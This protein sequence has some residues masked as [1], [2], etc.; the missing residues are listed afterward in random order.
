MW[1]LPVVALLIF[2]LVFLAMGPGKIF[3]GL[4]SVQFFAKGSDS[5]FSPREISLLWKAAR[6]ARLEKP[7]ALFVSVDQ[8]DLTIK[9]LKNE[10]DFAE[11][12]RNSEKIELLKKLFDYRKK[13]EFD[14]PRYKMGLKSTH[15]IPLNQVLKLRVPGYQIFKCM[16]VENNQDYM[17][18][19]YPA[20]PPVG[21]DFSWRNITLN[22]Y[23]WKENDA[24]YFF[25]TSFVEGYRHNKGE[26]MR[27]RHTNSVLRSQKRKSI[28]AVSDFS[29]QIHMI[30]SIKTASDQPEY[31]PG[32]Q[33]RILD[34]SEDGAAVRARGKGKKGLP[35]K[36][37]FS[38]NETIIAALGVV[39][40]LE[41]DQENDRSLL[42]LEFVPLKDEAKM[43]ILSYVYDVDRSR[44]AWLQ[45]KSGSS[46][47]KHRNVISEILSDEASSSAGPEKES[48]APVQ[49]SAQVQSPVEGID[50]QDLL[51]DLPDPDASPLN[52]NIVMDDH[53]SKIN[54]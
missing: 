14:K 27:M 13:I 38:L 19:T 41:Y 26:L 33:C 43:A 46:L 47:N 17:T 10:T 22:V 42:H 32:L 28:R 35:L 30:K 37:Q 21:F 39:K 11:K 31:K 54:P 51:G 6:A 3:G 5:G 20:G 50:I 25:Q 8:L 40:S 7:E 53:I 23:F 45:Q 44:Q 24:G 36:L 15:E 4:N 18:V 48:D 16:V 49:D 1:W 34:I 2:V 29:A 12:S 52:D 9:I